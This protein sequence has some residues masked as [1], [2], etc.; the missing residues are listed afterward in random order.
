MGRKSKS[1]AE[2]KRLFADLDPELLKMFEETLNAA[3]QRAAEVGA[4]VGAKSVINA[5]EEERRKY[6]SETYNRRYANTRLLLQYYRSLNDFTDNAVWEGEEDNTDEFI[7][8]MDLMSNKNLPDT[9][10]VNSIKKSSDKTIIIM[11]HVNKMLA[12]YEKICQKSDTAAEQRR[13]RVIRDLY[14]LPERIIPDE[15]AKRENIH[16]R[17]VY[18]D[19][20]AA[21]E[22]LT[23]LLFGFDGIEKL[24]EI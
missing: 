6:R 23:I 8:I 11:K 22:D 1:I 3:M 9:V 19:V 24:C 2:L 20:D 5:V 7:D 14:L 17:T 4:E 12:E 16:I 18:K 13:W 21:I 15:I 10:I